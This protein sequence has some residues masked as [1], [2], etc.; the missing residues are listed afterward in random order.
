MAK[1]KQGH[2]CGARRS[3]LPEK[4]R[5]IHTAVFTFEGKESVI[6]DEFVWKTVWEL[7]YNKE[8]KGKRW[9]GLDGKIVLARDR[10]RSAAGIYSAMKESKRRGQ[11]CGVCAAESGLFWGDTRDVQQGKAE[12][13]E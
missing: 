11:R 5:A 7:W 13:M 10:N 1:R 8:Y 2:G 3:C 4:W 6:F 9:A 12:E